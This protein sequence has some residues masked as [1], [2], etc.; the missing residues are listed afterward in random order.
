M[1]LPMSS[2]TKIASL[3]ILEII[4]NLKIL[5]I[6]IGSKRDNDRIY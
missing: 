6:Y 3:F 1:E 5:N 4:I 2:T